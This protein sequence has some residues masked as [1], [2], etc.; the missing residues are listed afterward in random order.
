[1]SSCFCSRSIEGHLSA[2]TCL[3]PSSL[4]ITMTDYGS[5]L[6]GAHILVQHTF[7]QGT[8]LPSFSGSTPHCHVLRVLCFPTLLYS[9]PALL[10]PCP[11]PCALCLV[12]FLPPLDAWQMF[13][14][15][16]S[17]FCFKRYLFGGYSVPG[18]TDIE[19]KPTHHC[20]S[21][22]KGAEEKKTT[23]SWQNPLSVQWS[24][25]H[26]PRHWRP[27]VSLAEHH[28]ICRLVFRRP[29][30][31]RNTHFRLWTH[32]CWGKYGHGN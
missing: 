1:M 4:A 28:R 12:C 31:T 13:T 7:A 17:F 25:P 16:I 5:D 24:V 26:G 29:H 11:S 27:A 8:A 22:V 3:Q 20:P 6:S 2:V 14:S 23:K 32:T 9:R 18:S 21:S 19:R 10:T 15:K 30:C